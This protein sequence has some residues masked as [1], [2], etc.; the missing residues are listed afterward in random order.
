MLTQE[1]VEQCGTLLVDMVF[2]TLHNG[3]IEKARLGFQVPP[4]AT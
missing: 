1:E 2:S 3:A 4:R